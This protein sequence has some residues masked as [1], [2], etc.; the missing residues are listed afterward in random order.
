MEI[1]P[2]DLEQLKRIELEIFDEFLRICN[3][4][5]I[6]YFLAGGTLLGAVRHGGFI[7]WDDD[8]DIS[9]VRSEYDRFIEACKTQLSDKYALQCFDTEPNCGL[10]FAKIRKKGTV[11]SEDY[12]SHINM[13]QGIWID[14]FV[15][16]AVPDDIEAAKRHINK[17]NFLKNLYIVKCGYKM[18]PNMSTSSKI[19]YWGAKVACAIIP[20][21]SIIKKLKAE[22]TMFEH[23]DY[24][25]VFPY[26][27]AYGV[28]KEIQEKNFVTDLVSIDFE[29]R[30]CLTFKNYDSYLTG[31]YGDYMQLPPVEKRAAGVHRL[32]KLRFNED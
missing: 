30:H 29:G 15:Y 10:V 27:G 16:D 18:P 31:H 32:D 1:S 19:A 6:N 23:D 9:M 4:N 8:I 14:V 2:E 17:V 3:E 12:S 11:M 25:Y 26:G 21:G 20:L 5:D 7:P 13:S 24:T 28:D 22:M